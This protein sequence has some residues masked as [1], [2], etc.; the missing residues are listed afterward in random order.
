SPDGK[1][2]AFGG[3]PGIVAV[4]ADGTH[5]KKI[6]RVEGTNP[7]WSPDGTLIAFSGTNGLYVV[8]ADGGLAKRLWKGV[9]DGG[10]AWSP[11]GPTIALAG[12]DSRLDLDRLLAVDAD[13]GRIRALA[14]DPLG[15]PVRSPDGTQI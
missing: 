5:R 14:R 10:L 12:Y 7:A 3:R 6:T 11:D 4:R 15:S 9:L 8:D 2:V 13:T 1:R